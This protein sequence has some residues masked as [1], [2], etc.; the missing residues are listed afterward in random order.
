MRR[1]SVPKKTLFGGL[2]ELRASSAIRTFNL[3]TLVAGG[4]RMIIRAGRVGVVERVKL[5]A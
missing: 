1:S 4:I 3:C 2:N 5:V